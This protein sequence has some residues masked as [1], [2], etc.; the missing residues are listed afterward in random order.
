MSKSALLGKVLSQVGI[1]VVSALLAGI[2][3]LA[4][5]AN[6]L[7]G[8]IQKEFYFQDDDDVTPDNK[9]LKDD[10]VE[11][12][13]ARVSAEQIGFYQLSDIDNKTHLI[14]KN[15]EKVNPYY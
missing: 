5:Q 14:T 15:N 2:L 3:L 4:I 12:T 13:E 7:P 10:E 9:L 11:A 1:F 8:I 6:K